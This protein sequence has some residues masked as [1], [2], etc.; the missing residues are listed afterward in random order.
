MKRLILVSMI[1]ILAACSAGGSELERNH[2]TWEGA[3][4]SRYRFKLF[5]SCFCPFNE[6]MP[7]T[8]E[9]QD[10][11]VISMATVNGS[12]VAAD[13]PQ[14]EYFDRFGTFDRLFAELEKAMAGKEAGEIIVKYDA[15]LGFPVEASIDYIKMAVDDELSIT[16]S[17]FEQ[18]P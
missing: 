1:L 17:E 10:G 15:K 18:L 11:E 13:D 9:V 14:R 8:I 16:V 3:G 12:P 4:I 6:Q 7:L 2:Q 5:L